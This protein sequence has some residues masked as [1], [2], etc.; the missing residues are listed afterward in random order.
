[1]LCIQYVKND[2][3]IILE[4]EYNYYNCIFKIFTR[5]ICGFCFKVVWIKI[6]GINIVLNRLYNILRSVYYNY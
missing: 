5:V 2:V 1:M 6:L 3:E 4:I